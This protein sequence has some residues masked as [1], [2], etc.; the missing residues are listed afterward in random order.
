MTRGDG[1]GLWAEGSAWLTTETAFG[2][3][4]ERIGPIEYTLSEEPPFEY[5]VRSIVYQQLAGAAAATI[6]GR[7]CAV[8]DEQVSPP[9]ILRTDPDTLRAA[10]LS[11]AKL[12]AVS[13]LAARVESGSLRLDL[14]ELAEL[15]DDAIVERLSQVW[16]VGQWTARM[17]L[18][19]RLGRADVWPA[20][21]LGVRSGWARIHGLDERPD[22]RSLAE[23]AGHLRPHRSAAAWYCWRA[24]ELTDL[25]GS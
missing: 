22:A 7:V 18:M 23:G 8:L 10:G 6:H 1:G 4:V 11:R 14:A 17:F 2:P 21:D 15:T 12:R 19:F 25:P 24:L 9:T 20:G 13:D 3:W 5:L 16:G